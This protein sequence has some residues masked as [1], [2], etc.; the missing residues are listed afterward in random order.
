MY[1]LLYFLFIPLVN[2]EIPSFQY[3]RIFLETSEWTKYIST[4]SHPGYIQTKIECGS[5]CSSMKDSCDMFI[6]EDEGCFAGHLE[7]S[8]SHSMTNDLSGT[9]SAYIDLSK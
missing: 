2:T 7:H 6:Y 5:L 3:K 8:E 1:Q 9:H 4:F